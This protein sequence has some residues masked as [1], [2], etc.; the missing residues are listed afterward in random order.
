MGKE[1]N[2]KY[3]DSMFEETY[4]YNIHY[5]KS[6]YFHLWKKTIT[7]IENNNIFDLGCGPGQFA[8]MLYDLN[9]YKYT[10]IDFSNVAIEKAKKIVPEYNFIVSE[11][12]ADIEI[13][14]PCTVTI[15]ETLEHIEQDIEIIS[16]L[17]NC[18]V[19]ASVPSY[20]SDGH[21]RYFK[22]E[23]E[24]IDRYSSL[25]INFECIKFGKFFIF[26]GNK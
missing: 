17:N 11:L 9:K 5:S 21:V 8:N 6:P 7:F 4:K 24:V 12:N 23:K 1:L 20:D 13:D 3:Y 22:S 15:I 10:G 25:F 19:I 18:Q 26:I 2:S 14:T 16:K